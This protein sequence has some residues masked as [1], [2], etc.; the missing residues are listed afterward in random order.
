MKS[1]FRFVYQQLADE[2]RTSRYEP[3]SLLPSEHELTDRFQV[4][5]ETIRKAL[6]LLSEH[7]YIQKVQGK[8]SVVLDFARL[9][10]P[11]SG[12][13]SFQELN[14]KLA[15][16]ALTDV[17]RFE[18]QPA[19]STAATRLDLT[20]G[21]PVWAVE[22]VRTIEG[23]RVILDQELF[24]VAVIPKLTREICEKSIYAY[25][26][27]TLGLTISFA[28]KEIVVEEATPT[29]QAHLDLH[30]A[31]HVVV[32]RSYTYL[33]D[34]TLFQYTA[35]RHRPDKFRFVDFARRVL[36]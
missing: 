5:R 10:F 6:K 4:S 7:G 31:T 25:I 35:S 34:A 28:K 30:G 1:K 16:S 23:E 26:E 9:E 19:S 3:G 33:D 17:I 2:I 32:V 18:Q 13:M 15:L 20:E 11:F 29:D 12:V 22:R 14:E 36:Q 8:G 27:G 21:D 24:S